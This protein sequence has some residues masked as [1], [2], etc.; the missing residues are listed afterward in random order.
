[1]L[2]IYNFDSLMND[3]GTWLDERLLEPILNIEGGWEYWIQ[4]DFPAWLDTHY[5]TQYDFR[6][7]VTGI[8]QNG[9]ID[10]LVNSQQ[11]PP[12][13]PTAVEIKAQTHKYLQ[14]TFVTDVATDVNKLATLGANYNKVMLVAT[15]DGPTYD[16]LIGQNFTELGRYQDKVAFLWK[17]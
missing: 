2:T 7:E 13:P 10:W 4:I 1:M 8:L 17:V 12:H 15:I 11:D 6:R 16:S 14:N 5:Q 3:L 9:R